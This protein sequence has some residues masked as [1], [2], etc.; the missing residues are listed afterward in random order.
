MEEHVY[1]T[2]LAGATHVAYDFG[3]D[4]TYLVPRAEYWQ[5]HDPN[6]MLALR[7]VFALGLL[8]FLFYPALAL[9]FVM[10]L[11]ISDDNVVVF[12]VNM[13]SI[14]AVLLAPVVSLLL[15]IHAL[16][17]YLKNHNAGQR[18]LQH[19]DTTDEET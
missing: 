15:S 17:L 13:L 14:C 7:R 19:H 9:V 10:G 16:I 1:T 3:Q 18:G 11:D 6:R 4:G 8:F 12:S 5:L 2:R